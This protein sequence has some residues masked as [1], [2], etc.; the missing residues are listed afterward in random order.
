MRNALIA[1]VLVAGCDS[2]GGELLPPTAPSTDI[3]ADHCV[4]AEGGE[5]TF[6]ELGGIGG[7]PYDYLVEYFIDF[8]NTCGYA[9]DVHAVICY[10]RDG[11]RAP[12]HP[13]RWFLL[14]AHASDRQYYG[15]GQT[16][17][18][19]SYALRANYRACRAGFGNRQRCGQ[20]E[21]VCP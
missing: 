1:A 17:A 6:R 15:L 16:E 3:R 4:D 8:A 20:A 9:V 19:V 14:E 10:T 18:G 11:V 7:G 2:L 13:N 12:G 5:L 21:L